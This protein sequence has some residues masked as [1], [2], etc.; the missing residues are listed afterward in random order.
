M[1]TP[2]NSTE[3]FALELTDTLIDLNRLTATQSARVVSMLTVLEQDLVRQLGSIDFEGLSLSRRAQRI[4]RLLR[5]VRAT[6]KSR[7]SM[8]E[9][10][11]SSGMREIAALAHDSGIRAMNTVFSTNLITAT[12][13]REDL[14]ALVDRD[15][16]LGE[17]ARD[18]WAG[19]RE[20]T[21]R[22]F[23]REMRLGVAQGE[24]NQKLIQRVRGKSTGRTIKVTLANG[25]T[26]R[27]RE[28]VGGLMDVSRREAA[29]L[30]RTS[31][32]SVSNKALYETYKANDDVIKGTEAITTLDSRTSRICMA[33]TG[34][35]WFNNGDPMPE[36]STQ[37]PFPG[38]PPWHFQCR[39]TLSP[40]T[41][42]WE[43][44]GARVDGPKGRRLDTVPNSRR[45][46][47]DGLINTGR[48][49]TFDDWLRIKG[50][51]YARRKLGPGLFDL[52]KSGKITTSQLIDQGGNIIPIRELARRTRG[53]R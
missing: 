37:E 53:K 14:R 9:A 35:A 12:L 7:Y 33:R 40:V 15:V 42:S 41:Y 5:G 44:L 29:S 19:Q 20:G 24:T 38:P 17:P 3:L 51:G 2:L 45:A 31:A 8:A 34:S 43:E 36:S 50:D 21:R 11:A 10:R 39:S 18:W 48:V 47:F 27:V 49:R 22:R 26:R 52:W 30:V 32:Q 46:S 6:I 28:F 23:A 4:E 16:V 1:A 13:T 25:K